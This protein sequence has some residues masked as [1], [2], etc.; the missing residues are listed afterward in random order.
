[1]YR[2]ISIAPHDFLAA[3]VFSIARRL[4]IVPQPSRGSEIRSLWVTHS[5][6]APTI[7]R[8]YLPSILYIIPVHVYNQKTLYKDTLQQNSFT[9]KPRRGSEIRSLWVT[10]SLSAPTIPR[11]CIAP[12]T[13]H[14][15]TS[16]KPVYYN[17]TI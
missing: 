12:L 17:I 16:V 14:K 13:L 11:T 1:M 2:D 5:L 6:S 3:G 7:P 10:Q 9:T 8:T 4:R 15:K